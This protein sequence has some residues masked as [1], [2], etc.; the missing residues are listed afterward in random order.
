MVIVSRGNERIKKIASL[1]E[2]KY[3]RLY[4]E[5]LVEGFKM[6]KEAVGARKLIK[7]IV[8]TEDAEKRFSEDFSLD[9]YSVGAEVLTV[10]ESVMAYL[11][12]SVTPQ[13]VVAVLA[14][15]SKVNTDEK[16]SVLLDGISDPGNMGTIIRTAA[17]VGVKKLY[18]VD[19][20]DPFSPKAVRSSMSGIYFVDIEEL[21]EEEALA[22]LDGKC[23]I[24]ADMG[25][26]NVFDFT[27]PDEYCLIIGS[28]ASG[29]RREFR[30]IADDVV[31]IPMNEASESLNAAVS[32]SVI[33]YEFNFGK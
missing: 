6:V 17:A 4:G 15:E 22:K 23:T 16:K 11:S 26:K 12:D 25:G 2:K 9:V 33:L 29:V 24:I 14:T 18:L 31:A 28:E 19:C 13:G 1:K 27:P 30:E 21:G 10:S 20:C 5:Y 3:R 7:V 32:L 8:L